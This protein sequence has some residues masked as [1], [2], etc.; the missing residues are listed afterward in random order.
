MSALQEAGIHVV[1][2]PAEIGEKMLEVIAKAWAYLRAVV[3]ASTAC[4]TWMF[5]GM[6][7]VFTLNLY[8]ESL[9]P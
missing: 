8:F 7:L 2:T 1:K 9:F 5:L 4:W 6:S 3:C